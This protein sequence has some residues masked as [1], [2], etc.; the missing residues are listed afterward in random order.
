LK[1]PHHRAHGFQ[2]NHIEFSG[3]SL[4]E[5]LRWKWDALRHGLPRPP[6]TPIPRVEPDL[7]FIRRNTGADA[8]PAATW[9][10]HASTLV[11]ISGL[12]LLTDPVFSERASP[13]SFAGP[14]RHSPPGLSIAELPHI[15]LVLISHNHYDHLDAPTV[16]ALARQPAGP[17]LFVVPLGLKDWL[18]RRGITHAVELDW[19]QQHSIDS[20]RGR[21]DVVLVPAQHWSSRSLR[22]AMRTLWGGFAV[23]AG[24]AHVFFAG[25]TGYSRDFAEMRERFAPRQTPGQ[26]GGFDLALLPIGAYEP[27]WFM[28]EQHVNVEEA[29]KIHRDLGAKR[30]LG[31]HW[32]TFEL[33]DEPLDEPPRA[34]VDER[35]KAGLDEDQFFTLALGETRRIAPRDAQPVPP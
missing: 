2:N 31:V 15:D 22:D 25:D 13:F 35:R 12:S 19:W 1:P 23:F 9:V 18:A 5:V 3:K 29:V 7:D 6:A 33:T 4:G 30:S 21:V 26:G 14:K 16:E 24:D 11:Q 28:R 10:G 17:P 34:L 27:R 8:T 20:P 32:G